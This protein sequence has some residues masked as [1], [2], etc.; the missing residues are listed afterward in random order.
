MQLT[1]GK[2]Y[3]V[4]LA[5]KNVIEFRFEGVDQNGQVIIESP[6][7]SGNRVPF[8]SVIGAYTAYWEIPCP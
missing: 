5:N 8:H 7:G 4:L 2:C 6:P 3:A 1:I